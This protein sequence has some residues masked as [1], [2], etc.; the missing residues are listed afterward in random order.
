MEGVFAIAVLVGLIVLVIFLVRYGKKINQKKIVW[1]QNWALKL[2]LQH[3]LVKNGFAKL[4]VLHG[5]IENCP[6][7]IYEKMVGSGKNRAM[8]TYVEFT[9]SPFD[10]DF[11]IAK[12]GFF[13]KVGKTFGS[14]D[15]EFNDFEFDKKFLLK[16]K[17]EEKFRSIMDYKAQQALNGIEKDLFGSIHNSGGKFSYSI[18]GGFVKEEK[19]ADFERILDFM[20]LLIKNRK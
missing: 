8:H 20:R 2:G 17:E 16:S 12:E 19:I 7:Q 5:N 18:P 11:R 14:K 13:S 6:V 4:N 15:I 9:P 1:Y 10:F 3:E